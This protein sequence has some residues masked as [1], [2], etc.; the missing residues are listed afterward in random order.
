MV[1][2]GRHAEA[3]LESIADQTG[4]G[5]GVGG[6]NE[7]VQIA[8]AQIIEELFLGDSGLER[9]QTQFRI[10]VQNAIHSRKVQN[11]AAIAYRKRAPVTPVVTGA[12]CI[13]RNLTF[14]GNPN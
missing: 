14:V 2:L 12:D 13:E 3:A 11:D 9:Y 1:F 8:G 4:R 6:W 7:K 10:H 5:P